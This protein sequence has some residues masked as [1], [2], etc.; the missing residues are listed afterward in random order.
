MSLCTECERGGGGE[1][2]HNQIAPHHKM[3]MPQMRLRMFS[4]GLPLARFEFDWGISVQ[5]TGGLGPRGTCAY[6][7]I[8]KNQLYVQAFVSLFFLCTS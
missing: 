2:Q 1:L 4:G 7:G 3:W 6:V 8:K 5:F